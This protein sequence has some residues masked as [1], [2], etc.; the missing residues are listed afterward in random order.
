MESSKDHEN[1]ECLGLFVWID[2]SMFLMITDP[3]QIVCF[4]SEVDSVDRLG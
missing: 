3:L 1:L 4:F 2:G